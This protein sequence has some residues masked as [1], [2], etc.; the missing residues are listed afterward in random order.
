MPNFRT[1]RLL[2][3]FNVIFASEILLCGLCMGGYTLTLPL[4]GRAM[5]S[6][7][8]QVE[9]QAETARAQA[10]S[11]LEAEE[12]SAKTPEEKAEVEARRRD[13]E[14]RPKVVMPNM[15]DLQKLGMTDS[16][17][18]SWSMAEV[19]SGLILNVMLL[20]SGIGLMN[21]KGWGRSLGIWTG[22]LKIVRLGLVYGVFII[23]V[24]PTVS[25][26]IGDAV[27]EMMI[28]QQQAAGR[29][30]GGMPASSMFVRIYTITYSGMGLGMI[31]L[32]SVY[33]AIMVWFLTRP[34][35]KVACSNVYKLPKEPNQPW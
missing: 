18:I 15:M 35:A 1:P 14:S 22:V 28:A 31:A 5:Q 13:L 25:Q 7:T 16:K 11:A 20:A 30:P 23:V 12:E 29:G 24:V 4:W 2:G 21:W 32:G 34:G 3:I 27:G 10:I 9:K 8:Q 33:P 26:K 6:A 17:L 19:V